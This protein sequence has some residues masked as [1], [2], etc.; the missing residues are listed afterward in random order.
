MQWSSWLMRYDYMICPAKSLGISAWSGMTCDPN[1]VFKWTE[2][3]VPAPI[4][5][6]IRSAV[7]F[8][9][10]AIPYAPFQLHAVVMAGFASLFAPFGGFFA[11]GFKRAFNIKGERAK[12]IRCVVISLADAFSFIA[13]KTSA[14]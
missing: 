13:G 10:P 9:I 7:G 12:S 2:A 5:D 11:S 1:P 4:N 3:I 6:A 14:S 8:S